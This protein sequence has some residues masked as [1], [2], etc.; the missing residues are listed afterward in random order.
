MFVLRQIDIRI[1]TESI[2]LRIGRV[3][4]ALTRWIIWGGWLWIASDAAESPSLPRARLYLSL[5]SVIMPGVASGI[6]QRRYVRELAFRCCEKAKEVAKAE[7]PATTVS[8]QNCQAEKILLQ[9]VLSEQ[10]H[11]TG[12][13]LQLVIKPCPTRCGS[14]VYQSLRSV[15][16]TAP[17]D[18]F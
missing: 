5:F 6:R 11:I 14:L 3:S 9:R 15:L 17:R 8:L 18:E 4:V 10:A 16:R 12:M 7:P 1:L 2:L 13:I